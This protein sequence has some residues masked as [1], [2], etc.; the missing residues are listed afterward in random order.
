MKEAVA[1]HEKLEKLSCDVRQQG[2]PIV[3]RF[4]SEYMTEKATLKIVCNS[5]C[6]VED[7][8]EVLSSDN[9]TD[10]SVLRASHHI[11]C[12]TAAVLARYT[13][14]L[15]LLIAHSI[16]PSIPNPKLWIMSDIERKKAL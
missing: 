4:L 15:L 6:R 8:M 5:G 13:D 12:D 2:R 11:R 7:A 16:S 1:S 3:A 10:V 9:E 14:V